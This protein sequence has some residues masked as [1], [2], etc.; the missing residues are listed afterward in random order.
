MTP[1]ADAFTAV[2][3]ALRNLARALATGD[4]DQVLAAESPLQVATA[5]LA[6][7]RLN[8]APLDAARVRQAW[9]AI[10]MAV[11]EC[12]A[13][14]ASADVLRR[15]LVPE[16]AYSHGRQTTAAIHTLDSRV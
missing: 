15:V 3:S 12:Q 9:R 7:L 8:P 2:E 16:T 11:L 4:A 10:L 5:G 13:L 6:D 1:T 14:G